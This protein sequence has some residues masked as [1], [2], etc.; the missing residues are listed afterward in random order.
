MIALWVEAVLTKAGSSVTQPVW[1][2]QLADVDP[3]LPFTPH[4]D[5]QVDA[6]VSN[7]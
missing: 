6:L 2:A 7:D 5:R 3:Q 1:A 4:D